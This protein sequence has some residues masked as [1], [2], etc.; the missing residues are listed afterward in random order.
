MSTPVLATKVLAPV[1]RPR[2]VARP[3]LTGRLDSALR[4]RHRL[5]LVSAPAGFGKTTAL[6]TWLER[7]RDTDPSSAV[8]WISLDEDDNDLARL[9]HHLVAALHRAG[10]EVGAP[11]L[12][13]LRGSPGEA[14]TVLVNAVAYAV[15]TVPRDRCVV[16][17]DDYHVVTAPEVHQAV[18]FLLDHLPPEL[19]L[20]LATRSDPPLPL[21]RLRTRAQLT[22][23]RAADLRFTDDEALEFLRHTM[24]LDLAA[25]DAAVLADRT[26]GWVAGL[27]LA[28]LSLREMHPSEATGFITD[29][30]G[31]HRFVLD[32]LVDEVLARQPDEVRDFLLST[33]V[34]QRL[35]G[36]LCDALTGRTDGTRVLEDL[37]RDNL[38]VVPLGTDRRWYRYHHLFAD[39][40]LARLLAESPGRV[41]E[42]HQR[43]SAWHDTA[44]H[45]EEAVRH[46][47]AA[48][49]LDRA[50]RL[51]EEAVPHA[52]RTRQDGLLAVWARALPPPQVRRSP[53]L[54]TL[55]A[56]SDLM[57]GDLDAVEAHLV[58]AEAALV[59]GAADPVLA[60]AWADTEDL[61]SAPAMVEVYR[62]SVAQAR[63]DVAGTVQH[64]GR[65]MDLAGPGDHAARG[66]A[67]GFLGLAAWAA[68]DI[69]TALTTFTGAVRSLHAAGN[70]VDELDSTVVRSDMWLALGRPGRARHL[71]DDALATVVAAG[72]P[73][74][75]AAADLHVGLAELDL[76][77]NDLAGA[78][79]HLES[80]RLLAERT[81]ITENRHRWFVA[82]ARLRA[83]S[84]DLAE[85]LRLVQRAAELYRPGFYPDLRPI[86]AVRARLALLCGDLEPAVA[87]ARDTGIRSD[88][89]LSYLRE[90]E[91]LTLARLLLAEGQT[92]EA[93]GLLERL[94]TAATTATRDGSVL[95]AR[96]I[97]ALAQHVAGDVRGALTT[98]GQAWEEAPEP[99]TSVRLHLDEGAPALALLRDAAG[100]GDA[101]HRGLARRLLA[102]SGVGAVAASTGPTPLP[103]PLSPRELEVLRMLDSELTGPEIARQL[104][105]S[106]N[107]LRT[108]TRR[109]FTKLDV[110]N[111]TAAIRRAREHG[112]L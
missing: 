91:H 51:I 77:R 40:L 45:P 53:V 84:G 83:V 28:A 56:W 112:L 50:A 30:A 103:D 58:D 22:E 23:V 70:L 48:E 4:D 60:A 59:A 68:G 15:E 93:L 82:A 10:L 100:H 102:R 107:T 16:V 11:V 41:R 99:E 49:D 76:E 44:G 35:T 101:E 29:F 108:H 111:R 24:D 95:E 37:E 42:L 72:E 80:A 21:S 20:V 2:I 89:P 32:Y 36:P 25:G 71:Y 14:L 62:A 3:R 96:V 106:L 39:V 81:S 47:L 18:L 55:A 104:F 12:D 46:A 31:S 19:H 105:V 33:A 34:L 69:G 26:E 109:I 6:G 79:T 67:G 90:Y 74:P 9:L 5:T 85:A 64:A 65:A 27:Q 97:R 86:P 110:G 92:P 98:L 88:E 63:G 61:R 75:R 87:W 43:A 7:L 54:S 66:A 52:R 17:L 94:E 8:A 78:E 57:A 1:L 38:F 13:A 73:Y